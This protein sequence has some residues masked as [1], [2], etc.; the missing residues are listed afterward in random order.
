MEIAKT[1][2]SFVKLLNFF[3]FSNTINCS[4]GDARNYLISPY[5]MSSFSTDFHTITV[6]IIPI[7]TDNIFFR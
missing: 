5:K 1:V 3:A 4:Y 7:L 6:E 2:Q